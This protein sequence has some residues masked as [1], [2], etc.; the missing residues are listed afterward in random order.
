VVAC[1]AHSGNA[2]H[3]T[4]RMHLVVE[5]DGIAPY[6]LEH[7]Q[8]TPARKWPNP[9]D[10]L[11]V[12]VD[13]KKHEK[14]AIEFDQVP[15]SRE[16]ARRRAEQEAERLRSGGAAV[17][18][19]GFPSFGGSM[20]EGSPQ[21]TI[22]GGTADDIPPETRAQLEQMLGV[23]IDGDGIVGHGGRVGGFVAG[24]AGDDRLAQLERLARLHHSGALDDREFEA[25]KRRLLGS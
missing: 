20:S 8:M 18:P 24:V 12:V 5:V 25:E 4:C 6:S 2:T 3:Q 14:L 22:V 1:T 11:P 10:V 21:V 17:G 23:D 7:R 15:D 13:R 9:G 19:T 16:V